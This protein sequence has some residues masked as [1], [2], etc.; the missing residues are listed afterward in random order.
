MGN[1]SS[2]QM[3]AA[4]RGEIPRDVMNR[5]VLD[6]PGFRAKLCRWSGH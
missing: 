3:L 4:A 6:R 2:E 5:E 1:I